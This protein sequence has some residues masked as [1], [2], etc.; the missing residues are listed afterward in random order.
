MSE[1]AGRMSVQVGAH[2]LE[3]YA[4]YQKLFGPEGLVGRLDALF[5]SAGGLHYDIG[6]DHWLKALIEAYGHQL[7][8]LKDHL[9]GNIAGL[10]LPKPGIS[11]A[12]LREVEELNE[13]H[14]G[15]TLEQLRA[16]A[17]RSAARRVPGVVLVAHGASKTAIAMEAIRR[18]LVNEVVVDDDLAGSL[19]E[20]LGGHLAPAPPRE[21]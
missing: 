13:R 7:K 18:R 16:C 12:K 8:T 6:T 1:V 2:F 17:E 4:G 20:A 9:V 15:L 19:V 10:V 21:D 14:I 11:K 5:T 3:K